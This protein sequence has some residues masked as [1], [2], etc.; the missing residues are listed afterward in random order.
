VI[1]RIL[2]QLHLWG[3]LSLGVY[4]LLIG[5]TGSVLVF[6]EEI[7]D[8]IAPAPH[9]P[10][11]QAAASIESVH[12]RIQAQVPGWHA[13]SLEP[14]SE[15]G[16]PWSTYL[17]GRG[18]GR[19][20]FVDAQ[21]NVIGERRLKGTWF[22]LF[23][24]FHSNLLIRNGR[25]YNGIAGLIVLVLAITGLVLWWP[26]KGEWRNAFRIVRRSNWKGINFDL[27][28]VGGAVTLLFTVLF[29]VTG[30]YFTWPAIYRQV[31]AV[32]LPVTKPVPAAAIVAE[33]E[34]RSLDELVRAAQE[35]ATDGVLLR[36]LVP[37]GRRQPVRVVFRH[38][39]R[40]E[41]HKSTEVVMNPY[42]AEVVGVRAYAARTAGDQVISW[43]GPLHTGHFGGAVV[44]TIWALAGLAMP[45]LFITGFL[46][47]WN[48]VLAPRVRRRKAIPDFA[49]LKPG[50][51]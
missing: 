36:V 11:G 23:E 27:H 29:C 50:A 45:G 34:R 37:E 18:G 47:W 19:S 14:P 5:V 42:T 44:K 28:R 22:E 35:R 46:M 6:R 48:R 21:G 49:G 4:A 3:G 30:A 13:W 39:D 16:Q 8:R 17:L 25:L 43:M 32:A 20:V 9:M 51:G 10:D 33:G 7:V 2:F 12:A 24:R 15:P 38:G 1:K 41:N 26:E 40:H 31:V